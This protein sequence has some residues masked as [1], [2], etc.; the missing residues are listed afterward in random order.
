VRSIK[1]GGFVGFLISAV[2]GCSTQPTAL[3][4][5]IQRPDSLPLSPSAFFNPWESPE[6]SQFFATDI[7][8]DIKARWPEAAARFAEEAEKLMESLH[9]RMR[10]LSAEYQA[11]MNAAGTSG[12]R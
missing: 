11:T 6:Y 3:N 12:N 4:P 8:Q 7:G 5:P 1:H 9:A 10:Q 2:V